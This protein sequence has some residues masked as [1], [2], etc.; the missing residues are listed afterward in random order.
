MG[1]PILRAR[2]GSFAYY[3]YLEGL[4]SLGWLATFLSF[5]GF[6]WVPQRW[7]VTITFSSSP[8]FILFEVLLTAQHAIGE[9]CSLHTHLPAKSQE[10]LHR[11]AALEFDHEV[12]TLAI[13]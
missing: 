10:T 5:A 2:S 8:L 6:S 12:I 4:K 7:A 9:R 13:G 1:P 3:G 11:P